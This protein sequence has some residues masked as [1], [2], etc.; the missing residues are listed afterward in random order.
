[1]VYDKIVDFDFSSNFTNQDLQKFSFVELSQRMLVIDQKSSLSS[2]NLF[3][4]VCYCGK[5]MDVF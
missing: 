4:M 5:I 2:K 1:M 3:N